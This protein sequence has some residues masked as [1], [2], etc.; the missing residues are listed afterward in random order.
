MSLLLC[1]KK[2]KK[3]KKKTLDLTITRVGDIVC[4]SL[5]SNSTKH[6]C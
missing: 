2:L 1:N 3:I 4:F 6:K 5:L